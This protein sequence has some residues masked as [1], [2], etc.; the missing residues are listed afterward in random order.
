MSA[1]GRK[2][3]REEGL[4]TG[5]Q[6]RDPRAYLSGW[7]IC[8]LVGAGLAIVGIFYSIVQCRL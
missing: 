4:L 3:A 6:R 5:W 8:L 7:A 1:G 2:Y